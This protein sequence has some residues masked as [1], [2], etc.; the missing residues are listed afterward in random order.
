MYSLKSPGGHHVAAWGEI[1]AVPD[2]YPDSEVVT[3]VGG[4]RLA[5][6]LLAPFVGRFDTSGTSGDDELDRHQALWSEIPVG[7]VAEMLACT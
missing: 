6:E 2:R 1:V 3:P 5:A 7:E 4:I